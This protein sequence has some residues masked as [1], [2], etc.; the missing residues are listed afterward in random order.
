M[1]QDAAALND[2][3]VARL[4]REEHDS[5]PRKVMPIDDSAADREDVDLSCC[6]LLARLCRVSFA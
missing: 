3:S 4:A 1:H 6:C 2:R 5:Q